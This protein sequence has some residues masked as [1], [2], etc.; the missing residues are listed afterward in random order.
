[1]S[2]PLSHGTPIARTHVMVIVP[3][4]NG[5]RNPNT[6]VAIC[7]IQERP[8]LPK[9]GGAFAPEL[10]VAERVRRL[11]VDADLEVHMRPEAVASAV[12]EADDLAL[13]HLLAD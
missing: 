8:Q 6:G 9:N 2:L 12:A 3:N 7:P 4:W 13:G 5:F 1:M 10:E 11:A